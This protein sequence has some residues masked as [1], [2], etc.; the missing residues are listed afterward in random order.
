MV[1][2]GRC[3]PAGLS[4][5]EPF[6]TLWRFV[7]AN[8]LSGSQIND[9]LE[10][11]RYKVNTV[12]ES[13]QNTPEAGTYW[14][15]PDL[16]WIR[17]LAKDVV[18]SRSALITSGH[19]GPIT[20]EPHWVAIVFDMTQPNG[21]LRYGD[22]FGGEIP[23]ELVAACRWWLNQHTTVK[24]ELAGLPIVHQEDGHSCG[25]LVDNAQ[26][27]FVD[28]SVPL[29]ETA[30]F[31]D[32]R[33]EVF[34]KICVR[35][36]EQLEIE[37]ALAIAEDED[38]DD[39]PFPG[40]PARVTGAKRPK[41]HP[42]APT[43]NPSPQKHRIFKRQADDAVPAPAQPL[44]ATHSSTFAPGPTV[45]VF[46]PGRL[47]LG[48]EDDAPVPPQSQSQMTTD[49]NSTC[50][51]SD[52]ESL[53]DDL[54]SLQNISDSEDDVSDDERDNSDTESMPNLEVDNTDDDA[55]LAHSHRAHAAPSHARPV[56]PPKQPSKRAAAGKGK[57]TGYWKVETAEEKAVRLEKEAREYAERAEEARQR[58]MEEK[59]KQMVR[60]RERGN[61][62]MRRHRERLRE[63]KIADGWIPG[64][65]RVSR[66]AHA[67]SSPQTHF[68]ATL[69]A[70]RACRPRRD[71]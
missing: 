71:L 32:A 64:K 54:P 29:L 67:L 1:P 60:D 7:G 49:A 55:V 17:D 38:S 25:I 20:D 13:M 11:L 68:D 57:I 37:R 19:L 30:K 2:W 48:P 44:F 8:W 45:D 21:V 6:H 65:N 70:R 14:T 5:S 16:R 9:M 69:E 58:E 35:A 40:P 66:A 61:E 34:N 31:M 52:V 39:R 24:L 59:R 12:P 50:V 10:L 53:P 56:S 15:A 42:D 63:A 3:K 51:A 43:P 27:D 46:G 28:L 41:G 4:D 18:Q 33:L 47:F 22:S 62:R 26:Q 36:L 23:G